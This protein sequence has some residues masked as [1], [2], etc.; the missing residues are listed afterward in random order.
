LDV[1]IISCSGIHQHPDGV[2]ESL[3]PY[4]FGCTGRA[5]C[6]VGEPHLARW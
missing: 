5:G 3:L 6:G 1:G 2:R 4:R